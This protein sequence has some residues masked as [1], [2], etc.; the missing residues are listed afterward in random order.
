MFTCKVIFSSH[1]MS[2]LQNL[3][4][5]SFLLPQPFSEFS[6]HLISFNI[7]LFTDFVKFVKQLLI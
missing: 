6:F 7:R 5:S 2:E 3:R 4:I 1:E